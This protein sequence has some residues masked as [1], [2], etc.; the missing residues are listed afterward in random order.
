M[1]TRNLSRNS[2]GPFRHASSALLAV[3]LS[4]AGAHAQVTTVVEAGGHRVELQGSAV[5]CT[6]DGSGLHCTAA[7]AEEPQIS[8]GGA[9]GGAATVVAVKGVTGVTNLFSTSQQITLIFTLPTSSLP[10]TLMGGSV[11]GSVTDASYNGTGGLGTVS[12]TPL[13]QA[14]ID[15]VPVAS[16]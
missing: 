4:G 12:G 6:L 8:A 3:L 11:G 2:S 5:R 16:K 15:G 1:E 13:Y 9:L 10:S 7:P 14:L